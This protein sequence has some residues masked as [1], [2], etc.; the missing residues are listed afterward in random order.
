MVVFPRYF[1]RSLDKAFLEKNVK[2]LITTEKHFSGFATYRELRTWSSDK[3]RIADHS[4]GT[5]G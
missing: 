5:G 3:F 4:P 2:Q 1:G